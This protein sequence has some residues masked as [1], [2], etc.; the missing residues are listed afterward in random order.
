MM[1]RKFFWLLSAWLISYSVA[2][3]ELKKQ[4]TAVPGADFYEYEISIDRN[5]SESGLLQQD[6]VNKPEFSLDLQPGA[7]FIRVR[8]VKNGAPEA[9]SPAE[10]ILLEARDTGIRF[11][12]DGGLVQV[13]G[14]EAPVRVQWDTVN[15]ADDYILKVEN[16]NTKESKEFKT[17]I[18]SANVIGMGQGKWSLSVTARRRSEILSKSSSH[19]LNV[20]Y[21]G[22]PQPIIVRPQEGDVLPSFE[23]SDLEWIRGMPGSKS[24]VI[25]KRLDQGG[26]IAS[27]EHLESDTQTYIPPLPA[28]RYQITVTDFANNGKESVSRSIT[29][30]LEDDPLGRARRSLNMALRFQSLLNFGWNAISNEESYPG[31]LSSYSKINP[32]FEL[33]ASTRVWNDWGL[34]ILFWSHDN[35]AQLKKIDL[36]NGRT[37]YESVSTNQNEQ[38]LYIGPSYT[39]S[40]FGPTKPMTLKALFGLSRRRY[41]IYVGAGPFSNAGSNDFTNE[42]FGLGTLRLGA[43]LR[44]GGWSRGWDLMAATYLE[45]PLIASGNGIRTGMPPLLPAFDF[46]LFARRRLFSEIRLNFGGMINLERLSVSSESNPNSKIVRSR[47]TFGPVLG[48]EKE[49]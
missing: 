10:K 42:K 15:G 12:P 32:R 46:R 29:V 6:R 17:A 30:I 4:W 27:Q 19:F 23:I 37:F 9:W 22:S 8:A 36:G 3:K 28:G 44:W 34:E 5:F 11:P 40:A 31:Y 2:A 14:Q 24:T 13:I 48:I 38:A 35:S 41:P 16:L 39:F 21:T 18:P 25:I 20:E 26:K 45:F 1:S 33:R 47:G 7:Y 43:D 49:F